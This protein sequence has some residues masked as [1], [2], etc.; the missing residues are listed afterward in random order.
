M[1]EARFG[2]SSEV[3]FVAA[4]RR[5]LED[6]FAGLQRH[7]AARIHVTGVRVGGTDGREYFAVFHRLLFAR[8]VDSVEHA[9]P[10]SR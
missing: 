6:S 3:D 4:E 8:C 1:K 5:I 9:G 2:S 7:H 10:R